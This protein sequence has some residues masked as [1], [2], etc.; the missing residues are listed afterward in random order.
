VDDVLGTNDLSR[1]IPGSPRYPN[2]SPGL[3]QPFL[4]EINNLMKIKET[5]SSLRAI[6]DLAICHHPKQAGDARG[7]PLHGGDERPRAP[8]N[9]GQM[10]A[11][12]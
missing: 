4:M 1:A 2:L 10:V 5:P 6:S 3:L 11:S 8:H 12:L 7:H 9:L